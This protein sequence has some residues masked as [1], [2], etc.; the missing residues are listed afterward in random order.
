MPFKFEFHYVPHVDMANSVYFAKVGPDLG[1][2][3][4]SYRLPSFLPQASMALQEFPMKRKQRKN[5]IFV[6]Q[7]AEANL[8]N[9]RFKGPGP[10]SSRDRSSYPHRPT[11]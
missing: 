6:Y 7:M 1:N 10:C 11:H 8:R 5:K 2:T 4:E 3:L 9:P